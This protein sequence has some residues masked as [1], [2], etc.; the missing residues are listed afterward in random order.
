MK[1]IIVKSNKWYDNLSEP[2]RTLFFLIAIMGSMIFAQYLMYEKNFM[3]A[4]PI[5]ALFFSF[6]RCGY[7]FINWY[8]WYKNQNKN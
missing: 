7:I 2:K 4:F 8:E 5:W 1:K 3:W 6:W